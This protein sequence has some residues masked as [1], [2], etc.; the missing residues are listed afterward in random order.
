MASVK[1][2]LGVK[3]YFFAYLAVVATG[4]T[5][6]LYMTMNPRCFMGSGFSLTD[7]HFFCGSK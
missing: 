5:P 1:T 6:S 7:K 4:S 2:D 3:E